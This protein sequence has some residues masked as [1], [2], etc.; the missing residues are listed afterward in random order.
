M[1]QKFKRRFYK[2]FTL[3]KPTITVGIFFA[4]TIL[5]LKLL[6]P[7]YLFAKAN[8]TTPQFFSSLLFNTEPPI[9]KH[10]GRTNIVILGIGG[11][12]HEGA[13][14]TDSVIFLS[15]DFLKHDSIMVS[16]PRDLWMPDLKDRL[17][18]AYHYGEEKK[19]GGGLIMAKAEVENIIGL[20][21]HYG[22]TI[23][24]S[25]FKRI[26]DLVGGIDIL[27]EKPFVDKSYP[28]EGKENDF[29][30]GDPTFAC[31]YEVV[32]FDYGWQH[33]DGKGALKYVRS[34]YAE[35]EEGTDFA[36]N[37]RQQQVI[38][39]LKDRFL[40]SSVWK[41]PEKLRQLFYSYDNA[42]DTDMNLS[43][44]AL[45]FK[46]F[47]NLTDNKIRKIVLDTGDEKKGIKGFLVNPPEWQYKGAWVLI[48]RTGDFDEI[49]KY[50]S[51]QVEN[52]NCPIK[53]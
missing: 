4:V 11:G 17:N 42:T 43:E 10:E 3:L 12:L 24:F 44:Q 18:T 35:G 15:M 47:L 41:N 40:A 26:I 32:K 46:Y 37:R 27:V 25:G 50:I 38:I 31:R 6:F 16:L 53:P 30:S 22:W 51:C 33:M 23:D 21:V 52:P 9:K 1:L 20:P 8:G 34:R 7:L 48:P 45:F 5:L 13:D 39:A 49:K 14:L 29:C 2:Y 19:K 28:L 36:R